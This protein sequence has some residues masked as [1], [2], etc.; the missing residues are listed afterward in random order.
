MADL[1]RV[2]DV[3]VEVD[4]DLGRVRQHRVELEHVAVDLELDARHVV[5]DVAEAGRG[6]GGVADREVDGREVDRR[7]LLAQPVD[8]VAQPLVVGTGGRQHDGSLRCHL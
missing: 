2:P 4:V 1:L 6:R 5:E 3:G 7:M 8:V